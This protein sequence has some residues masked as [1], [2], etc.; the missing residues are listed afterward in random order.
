MIVPG[1]LFVAT[2]MFVLTGAANQFMLLSA[3]FLAGGGFG[4]VQPGIQSLTIDR[5]PTSERSSALATLQGAWDVGGFG[6]AI[7][8]GPL[9]GVIGVAAAFATAG[10]VALAG[11]GGLVAGIVKRSAPAVQSEDRA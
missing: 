2:G 6:G 9:A 10:A 11:A 8:L 7:A 1:M 3:A 4:L 5:A